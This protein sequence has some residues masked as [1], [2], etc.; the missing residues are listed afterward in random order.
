MQSGSRQLKSGSQPQAVKDDDGGDEEPALTCSNLP[1]FKLMSDAS[2]VFL[3]VV[4]ALGQLENCSVDLEN[5]AKERGMKVAFVVNRIGV[6]NTFPSLSH[7]LMM[8]PP[9]S[10]P[11]GSCMSPPTFGRSTPCLL[12]LLK[13]S[14][15]M[16]PLLHQL[17]ETIQRPRSTIHWVE[18]V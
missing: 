7:L 1:N 12:R 16:F 4:D 10:V 5:V 11:Q 2:D 13:L 3:L 14:S 17:T 6:F 18:R 8:V 9:R 15:A